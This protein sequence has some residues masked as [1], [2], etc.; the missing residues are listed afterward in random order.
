[1]QTKLIRSLYNIRPKHRGGVMTIGNFDGVHQ[2]HQALVARVINKA[3]E[4]QVPSLV[5]TFEPHAF[6]FFGGDQ[7]SIP[8]LT[9]LREK[10]TALASCGV[11]YV[12]VLPFNQALADISAASFVNKILSEQLQ[13]KAV[14]IGDDFHFGY[15][16]Q[17][18][19]ALLQTMGQKLGFSVEAMPTI[20]IENERVSSTRVRK[21]L[22]EGNH[23]LVKQLL[24]RAY[25]LQG[26]VRWGDQRGRAWGFPTLNIFLHRQLTPLTG[27][28]TV[29][30]Y[31]VTNADCQQEKAWPGVANIGIRPTVDGTRALLEVHL[32]DFD[33]DVYGRYVV[34]EFCEKLR[35]EKRYPSIELLKEQIANDVL[36]ARHYFQKWSV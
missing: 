20:L 21:A 28:Y 11:D 10:L 2:G 18:D 19:F 13:I 8:R 16:R 7:L 36:A 31:G 26:R 30:V 9:R 23:E 35:D 24:G 5:V 15:Q 3:K 34:V 6:E 17:G 14:I 4:W 27:V 33:Q 29:R 12:L 1:M 25:T 22:A 32:L